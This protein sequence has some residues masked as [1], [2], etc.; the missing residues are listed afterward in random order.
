MAQQPLGDQGLL[1][2][3]GSWSHSVTPH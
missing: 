2:V 1:T 3:E